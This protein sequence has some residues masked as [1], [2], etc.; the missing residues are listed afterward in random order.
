MHSRGLT[1]DGRQS[2]GSER[3][4]LNEQLRL[5]YRLDFCA[6]SLGPT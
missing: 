1:F 2:V 6:F 5:V 3:V 4:E